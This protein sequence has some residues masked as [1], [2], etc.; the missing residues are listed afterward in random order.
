MHL[1]TSILYLINIWG[2]TI[3]CMKYSYYYKTIHFSLRAVRDTLIGRPESP[4]DD[5]HSNEGIF[6]FVG[7]MEPSSKGPLSSLCECKRKIS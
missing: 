6:C 7:R 3:S 2:D 1:V 4:S 5:L